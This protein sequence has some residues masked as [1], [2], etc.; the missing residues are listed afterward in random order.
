MVL[1]EQTLLACQ[2][3]VDAAGSSPSEGQTHGQGTII[4]TLGLLKE[5]SSDDLP[6]QASGNMALCGGQTLKSNCA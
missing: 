3:K 2:Q 1:E 5:G 6:V 4:R